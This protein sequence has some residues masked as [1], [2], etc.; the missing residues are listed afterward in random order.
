MDGA[1]IYVDIWGQMSLHWLFGTEFE[2]VEY[3]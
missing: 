3:G 1:E 2:Q